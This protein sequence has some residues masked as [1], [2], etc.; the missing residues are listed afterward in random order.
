MRLEVSLSTGILCKDRHRCF[1]KLAQSCKKK[2]T[3]D[4]KF[5]L[6]IR[7]SARVSNLI[8]GAVC[9][10]VFKSCR[11]CF[12]SPE[13]AYRNIKIF[14]IKAGSQFIESLTCFGS[15]F[16]RFKCVMDNNYRANQSK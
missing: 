11:R 8:S 6:D 14:N 5:S 2:P 1:I 10:A 16:I 7:R 15:Y 13:G 4:Y 12:M 3:G 9:T